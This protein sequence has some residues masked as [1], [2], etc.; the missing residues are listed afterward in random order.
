[1]LDRVDRTVAVIVWLAAGVTVAVLLF[2]PLFAGHGTAGAAPS[3]SG[4]AANGKQI[5]VSNCG[6]CHTLAAAGTSGQAG[7]DLDN[8]G[9]TTAQVA[10][11]VRNGGGGMP[12]FSGQLSN[13]QIQAVAAF[14]AASR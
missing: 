13:A 3:Y 10:A 6:S 2:G 9:L 4:G 7:P 12:P 14:V 5:F 1:M 8:I 11:Q